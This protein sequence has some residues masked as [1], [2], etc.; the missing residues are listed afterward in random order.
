M[1]NLIGTIMHG[2]LMSIEDA[3]SVPIGKAR[4]G[5][6]KLRAKPE[7]LPQEV[8][9]FDDV[10]NGWS[11]IWEGMKDGLVG[12]AHVLKTGERADLREKNTKPYHL[13]CCPMN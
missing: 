13:I 2:G 10:L 1:D 3:I 8:V 7:D 6:K 11:G 9:L 12:A 4:R 5:I